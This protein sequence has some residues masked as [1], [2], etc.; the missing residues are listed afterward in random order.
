MTVGDTIAVPD[1]A[2][3]LVDLWKAARTGRRLPH[4]SAINPLNLRPW[5]GDLSIVEVHD[6][7]KRFFVKLHGSDVAANIGPDFQRRY[8]EDC[9]PDHALEAGL[10]PYRTALTEV[11]PVFSSLTPGLLTG[12]FRRFERLIL[13][14]T[15]DDA[16][17][18]DRIGRFLVWVGKSERNGALCDTVYGESKPD[19]LKAAN[20]AAQNSLI[21]L[22]PVS[23]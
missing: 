20:K 13:P 22:R 6:G 1:I 5:I 3:G 17:G 18:S 7:E 9:L 21:V 11:A 4:K 14:F 15:D 16:A 12:T 2:S 19:D 10:Y 23:A 8:L